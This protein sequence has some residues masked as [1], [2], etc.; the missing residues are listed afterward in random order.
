[1]LHHLE[2]AFPNGE[3]P[4]VVVI[5]G[6]DTTSP[7]VTKAIAELRNQALADGTAS[8]PVEINT[9][10]QHTVTTVSLPLAGN[11]SNHASKQALD[12]LRDTLIPRTIGQVDGVEANVTGETAIN[13]DQMERCW[14]RTPRWS[15]GSCS[16]WRSCCC[17]SR[18]GRS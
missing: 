17:W 9:N 3:S 8:E 4:A 1:M 11:G 12:T 14:R 10:P 13:K 6:N 18:S 15:S 7:A 16:A 2:Q 5:Q